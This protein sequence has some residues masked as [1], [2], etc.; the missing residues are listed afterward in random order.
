MRS[1]IFKRFSKIDVEYLYTD[2]HVHT[3]WGDGRSSIADMLSRARDLGLRQIAFTEHVRAQSTYFPLYLKDIKNANFN[4]RID[5]LTGFEAKVSNFSGD[6][7]VPNDVLKM[8]DI[9]MASVHRFPMGRK[10][11]DANEFAKNICQEIEL[12]L[13]IAA[14]KMGK[15]NVLGHPGGMSLKNHNEFPGNFF[16]EIIIECKKNDIAFDLNGYYHKPVVRELMKILKKHDPYV[17]LGS[18]AH[19]V[20]ELGLWVNNWDKSREKS[21]EKR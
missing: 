5:V 2:K 6:I 8:V 18:D 21:R 4:N 3:I 13:S 17:S 20:D 9:K 19:H 7:D 14:I 1:R 10:L 11:F 16:E 15:C 12:E